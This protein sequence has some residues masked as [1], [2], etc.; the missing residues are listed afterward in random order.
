[1]KD[2]NERGGVIAAGVTAV[3]LLFGTGC[4]TRKQEGALIGGVAGAGIGAIAG[5]GAGALIGGAVGAATGA[6][7]G[8]SKDRR[9]GYRGH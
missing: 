9:Y 6:A 4:E 8:A 2:H 7:I 1:M 3:A 5:D